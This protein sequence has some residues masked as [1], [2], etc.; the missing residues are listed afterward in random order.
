MGS[1]ATATTEVG[2]SFFDKRAS[3]YDQEYAEPTAGG[4]ALR[5]R[6][7][8]VLSLFDQP[9]GKVLDV[10]CGPGVMA[11][12]IVD[13][14]CRYFGVDPSKKM[15]GI[16][17]D[18]FAGDP[19]MQ[20]SSADAT[21][22]TF[23]T[24]HFD[25]VLCIGVI[26]AVRDQRRALGEMVRV[27]K[28]GGTLIITFT[29]ALSPYS[30]WKKYVYYPAIMHLQ[31]MPG[32]PANNRRRNVSPP[33]PKGRTLYNKRGA[34]EFLK[35]EGA[36]VSRIVGYYFNV[37]LSPL[38]ELFPSAALAVTQR[39]VE[40]AWPAPEWVASGWIIKARKETAAHTK[41]SR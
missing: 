37:F 34:C 22:L 11:Q 25:A 26:D 35:S 28:P 30:W 10:G 8:K 39:L 18:R 1:R 23:P 2:E 41:V 38:D 5:V 6:R 17:R 24:A 7:E 14:D 16:C 21:S 40:G 3:D 4:Y 36:Q 20:F 13:R 19:R 27:L 15:L 12:Q 33:D 9:G 29:N 32:Y 31:A